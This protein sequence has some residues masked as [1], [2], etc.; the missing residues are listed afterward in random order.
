M[1]YTQSPTEEVPNNNGTSLDTYEPGF[2]DYSMEHDDS[3]F[4]P[5]IPESTSDN[6]NLL[7]YV[8]KQSLSPGDLRC[9]LLSSS[10]GKSN[11]PGLGHTS[12]RSN[13]KKIPPSST[14]VH[15]VTID[16]KIYS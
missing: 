4:S 12:S 5:S 9:F 7:A 3:P 2:F 10:T 11:T 1:L 16:G 14:S 6:S 8:T 15:I 13:L